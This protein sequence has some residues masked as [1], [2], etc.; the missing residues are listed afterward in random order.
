MQSKTRS[1][2]LLRTYALLIVAVTLLTMCGALGVS[3]TRPSPYVSVSRVV[4]HAEA[5]D[6]GTPLPP[7]MGTEREI[8]LSGEVARDASGE[9]GLSAGTA[10]EYLQVDVPV[11]TNV[12]EFSYS[13]T[14]GER[15]SRG[16]QVFTEAYVDYRNG[17]RSSVAQ[18]ITPPSIPTEPSEPNL[19]LVV[20]LSLTVGLGL[21]IAIAFAWDRLSPWLR[22]VPDVESHTGLPVLA[23]IPTLLAAPGERFVVGPDQAAAGAEAFGHLTA[24]LLSLLHQGDAHRVLITSP[25]AGAGKTTVTLNLAASLALAGKDTVVL[26]V[27]SRVT[28]MHIWS[29]YMWR[30][31]LWELLHDEATLADALHETEIEGLRILSRGGFAEPRHTVLNIRKLSDLLDELCQ[32]TDVVLIEAPPVIGAVETAILAELADL[33]LLVVDRRRGRRADA[34][35]AVHALSHVESRLSGC[36]VNDPGRKPQPPDVSHP[37]A[38]SR[39]GWSNLPHSFSEGHQNASPTPST[40]IPNGSEAGARLRA[41]ARSIGADNDS[42]GSGHTNRRVADLQ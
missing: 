5:V 17:S 32:A 14:T 7:D 36:V 23:T 24:R 16:A 6:G 29:G 2:G 34:S 10:S 40:T 18:I 26:S 27:D 21:G 11:D 42:G 3:L 33:T 38:P 1:V 4:V 39:R 35:A 12:L 28:A 22:D 20:A 30:P 41:G 8:A 31:G 19:Y 37:T 25:T 15:A 13:A 9:L